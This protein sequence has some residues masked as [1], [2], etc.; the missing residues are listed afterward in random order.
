[1]TDLF[2][3]R[4]GE[5]DWNLAQRFQGHTDIPLNATG[6]QQAELLARRLAREPIQAI[7]AS[8]LK[9]AH[10]TAAASGRALG[11]PVVA[12]AGLRERHFGVFEGLTFSEIAQRF[13]EE[14]RRWA[15]REP[16]FAVGGG[17]SLEDVA[18]RVGGV[19][20]A[21]AVRHPDDTIMLVT[22]GGALDVIYRRV[23]GINLEEPRAWATPNAAVNQLR[24]QGGRWHMVA[25]ADEE[26]L[27]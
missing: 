6:E 24:F 14:H 7:Y 21:L 11:L 16:R 9:R 25:W 13:P 19:L 20:D 17:E 5:T 10:A 26:H 18:R 15:S 12:E 4:H 8:D 22:H 3:V 1:L 23:M 2:V 27:R